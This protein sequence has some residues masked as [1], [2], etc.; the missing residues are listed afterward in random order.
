MPRAFSSASK[1]RGAST[2]AELICLLPALSALACN[3]PP[4]P[5]VPEALK[6]A[7]VV[8]VGK[9]CPPKILAREL[10]HPR[11]LPSP[12]RHDPTLGLL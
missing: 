7:D 10:R 4:P 2:C 1:V 12:Q 9:S 6:I 5:S 8:L 3:G 11:I